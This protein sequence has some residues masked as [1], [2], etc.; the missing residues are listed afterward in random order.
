M[1]PIAPSD[2]AKE[3]FEICKACEHLR[4]H[5]HQCSKCGCF[6]VAKVRFAGATCPIGK[7]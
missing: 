5:I 3:R 7:W 2:Q 6:M 1:N 4:P